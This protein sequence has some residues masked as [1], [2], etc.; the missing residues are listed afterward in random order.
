MSK[1][2]DHNH[3]HDHHHDSDDGKIMTIK[4]YNKTNLMLF[5]VKNMKTTDTAVCTLT[6]IDRFTFIANGIEHHE[7]KISEL[8][9]YFT[10]LIKRNLIA[11]FFNKIEIE[12]FDA[13]DASIDVDFLFQ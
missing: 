5:H 3:S 8:N 10:E 12:P 11:H 7:C 1:H 2:K 6:S 9:E 4:E 13:L